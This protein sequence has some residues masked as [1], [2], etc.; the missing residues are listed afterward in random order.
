[1]ESPED[2]LNNLNVRIFDKQNPLTHVRAQDM[3]EMD[4]L[5]ADDVPGRVN[6]AFDENLSMP[7]H[8]TASQSVSK[9]PNAF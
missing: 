4:G 8:Q 9:N 6:R 1:M 3:L 7:Q 5:Y 2:L